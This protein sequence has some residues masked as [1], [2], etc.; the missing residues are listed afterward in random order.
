MAKLLNCVPLQLWLTDIP[1]IPSDLSILSAQV[2]LIQVFVI[3]AFLGHL[4]L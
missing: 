4:S 2:A 1:F 3:V